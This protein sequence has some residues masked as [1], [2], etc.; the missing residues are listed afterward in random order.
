MVEAAKDREGEILPCH[1]AR[2]NGIFILV[3]VPAKFNL[4]QSITNI[5]KIWILWHEPLVGGF[6]SNGGHCQRDRQQYLRG[7][8][9]LPTSPTCI[10]ANSR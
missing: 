8:T 2:A 7:G 3:V 1:I 6:S 9:I 5:F 10:T 4:K